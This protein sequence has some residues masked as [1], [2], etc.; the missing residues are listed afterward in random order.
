MAYTNIGGGGPGMGA[1]AQN[2]QWGYAQDPMMMQNNQFQQQLG[3]QKD[4]LNYLKGLMGGGLGGGGWNAPGGTYTPS[5]TTTPQ[6]T[7]NQVYGPA[8]AQKQLN[9]IGQ[10]GQ[11]DI[12]SNIGDIQRRTAGQG[13][14]AGSNLE[15]WLETSAQGMGKEGY[16]G[17]QT[18]AEQAMR[19]A[20]VTQ[21]FN[22]QQ[23]QAQASLGAQQIAAEKEKAAADVAARR[24]QAWWDVQSNLARA[25]IGGIAGI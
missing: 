19:Q 11:K 18:Q 12:A 14:G 6:I 7:A 1:G 2:A 4:K 25:V 23:A 10:T 20:D 16:R 8:G 3:F 15:K 13:Y 21:G 24:Q 9:L 5:P 22:A 17:Q